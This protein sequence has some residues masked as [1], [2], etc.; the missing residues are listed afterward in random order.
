M[1]T[2]SETLL[3]PAS[4]GFLP[5]PLRFKATFAEE[6]AVQIKR[7]EDGLATALDAL[8]KDLQLECEQR[9]RPTQ[10]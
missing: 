1:Q 6:R 7:V 2:Q 5:P 3:P 9:P 8:R 4:N 10:F